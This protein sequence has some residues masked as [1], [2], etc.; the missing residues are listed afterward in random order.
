MEKG[1]K[2]KPWYHELD[3]KLDSLE[4]DG[5]NESRYEKV[6]KAIFKITDKIRAR[7]DYRAV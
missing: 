1:E 3:P 2:F 7:V 4:D 5:E 6:K